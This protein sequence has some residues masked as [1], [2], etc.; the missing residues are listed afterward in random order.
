[1]GVGRY[2]AALA[3]VQHPLQLEGHFVGLRRDGDSGAKR[4]HLVAAADLHEHL[5]GRQVSDTLARYRPPKAFRGVDRAV[6]AILRQLLAAVA[7]AGGV[8]L[9]PKVPERPRLPAVTLEAPSEAALDA[10]DFNLLFDG[11]SD[12]GQQHPL[13]DAALEERLAALPRHL[14]YRTSYKFAD[15]IL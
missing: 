14:C 3:P 2:P 9:L 13:H 7:A 11:A 12:P 5:A 4:A 6:V 8:R 1:M 15:L 10:P